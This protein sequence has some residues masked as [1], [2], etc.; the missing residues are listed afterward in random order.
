MRS[1]ANEND[2][3]R[4]RLLKLE[5]MNRS[6]VENINIKYNNYHNEGTN[7]LKEQHARQIRLLLDEIDKLKWIISEKNAEIQNQVNE[8]KELRKFLDE[9]QLELSSDI[10]NLKN[11]L[12]SQELRF[13]E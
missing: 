1:L 4:V 12:Y 11:K 9:T 3:L 7:T 8:K 6:E 2:E 5:E 13:S 10:E